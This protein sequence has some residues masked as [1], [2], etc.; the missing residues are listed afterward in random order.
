MEL[1]VRENSGLYA[2]R[3]VPLLRFGFRRILTAFLQA[4]SGKLSCGQLCGAPRR[5]CKHT[6]IAPCHPSSTCPEQR[7][8]FATTISCSCGRITATVPCGAGASSSSFSNDALFEASIIQKLPV[9]LQTIDGNGRKVPIGQRKL[10]CDAECDKA[11]RKRQLADAFDVTQPNLDSLHFGES[12]GT[13]DLLSDLMRREPK[14]VMAVEDRFK[15]MVLGKSK[16]G[17]GSNMKVH[18][19]CHM[20]KEKRDAV[21]YMAERW[22]LSVHAAGWEPKRFIVVH[23]TPKS[24]PPARI[25]GL[26]PGVPVIAPVYDPLIDMDPR[27]VVALL[28]L[29]RDADISALVLRFGGECE[30]VWLNDKNALSVFSDP[31]RAATALRRLDHVSAYHGAVTMQ[32][33]GGVSAAVV[34]AGNAWGGAAQGNAWKM[35][36][37][38]VADSWGP[39]LAFG[40]DVAIPVWKRNE[41]NPISTSANRWNMLDSDDVV[42]ESASDGAGNS[43]LME[44]GCSTVESSVN[45]AI[46]DVGVG[47]EVDDWEE[48]CE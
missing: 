40:T 47:H 28:D 27:L 32:Q 6:C 36:V 22:K 35:A 25:L 20:V 38:S 37:P 48:V 41:G 8:D 43:K 18:V 30:L 24:K 34:T 33:C 46:V 16:P 13:L 44:G 2:N 29:P 17:N 31:V 19:F 26:K 11:A 45:R 5:D 23:V 39:D 21:R 12:S 14:W 42:L 4:L 10:V 1:F 9:P 7:C 15:F 3:A